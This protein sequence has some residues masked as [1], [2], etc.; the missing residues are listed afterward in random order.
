MS[1]ALCE[2]ARPLTPRQPHHPLAHPCLIAWLR[3]QVFGCRHAHAVAAAS[4]LF[5]DYRNGLVDLSFPRAHQEDRR[6]LSQ[7]RPPQ[8]KVDLKACPH[9]PLPDPPHRPVPS[10][11]V[12]ACLQEHS[13][14][15]S[16]R[17]L[18]GPYQH[19]GCGGDGRARAP[20]AANYFDLPT[21]LTP[22]EV[23]A[24]Q[25]L[26]LCPIASLKNFV[27]VCRA[28]SYDRPARLERGRRF[29]ARCA[30]A[31]AR[32]ARPCALPPPHRPAH[33]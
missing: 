3:A 17:E 26:P 18:G 12:L 19:L 32:R 30:H 16:L 14:T 22:A 27:R 8:Q 31:H 1:G 25:T 10:P 11:P 13:S 7:V 15:T 33:R 4:T 23:S 29:A 2:G 28:Q 5:N 21:H 9:Y 24:P 6:S 20:L